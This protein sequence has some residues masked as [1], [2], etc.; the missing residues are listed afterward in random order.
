MN[1]ELENNK[2]SPPKNVPLYPFEESLDFSCFAELDE[3]GEVI[4]EPADGNLIGAK[5]ESC[6]VIPKPTNGKNKDLSGSGK[7][8]DVL[9]EFCEVK[10]ESGSGKHT[11]LAEEIS[12]FKQESGSGKRIGAAEEFGEVNSVN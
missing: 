3:Y 9:E 11:G 2:P 10:Q 7:H 12:Q 5:N 6:E 8:K 1:L 4:S